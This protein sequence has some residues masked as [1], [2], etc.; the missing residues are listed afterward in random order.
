[1]S[2]GENLLQIRD[3]RVAVSYA[4]EA[5]RIFDHYHFR[6]AQADAKK[7]RKKLQL[8]KPPRKSGERAWWA[9]DYSNAPRILD[10]EL[11]A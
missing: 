6:V 10:R 1:M 5:V 11:F 7:T 4:V 2:N 8:S 3:R 9:E